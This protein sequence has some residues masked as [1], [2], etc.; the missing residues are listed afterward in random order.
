[1]QTIKNNIAQ[2]SCFA[3]VVMVTV[4]GFRNRDLCILLKHFIISHP[5]YAYERGY[6]ADLHLQCKFR[7]F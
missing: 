6:L 7:R 4:Y 2:F 5:T 3:E 1:V